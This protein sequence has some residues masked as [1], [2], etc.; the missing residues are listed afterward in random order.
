MALSVTL[1]CMRLSWIFCRTREDEAIPEFDV[2]LKDS[3][4]RL[5]LPVVWMENHPLTIN[6]L[7]NETQALQSIGLQLELAH[8]H[9]AP[10]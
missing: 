8:P 2:K 10:A 4:V 6:D 3:R 9:H 5:V 7:E 1:L